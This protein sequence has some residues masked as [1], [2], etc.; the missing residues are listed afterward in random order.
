VQRAFAL[1]RLEAVLPFE[2]AEAE[3]D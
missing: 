2:P 1:S 3:I